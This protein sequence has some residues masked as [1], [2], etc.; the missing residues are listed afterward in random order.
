M[1]TCILAPVIWYDYKG[2]EICWN[3]EQYVSLGCEGG[4]N[5]LE[6]LDEFWEDYFKAMRL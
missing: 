2:D 6:L 3:G 1:I 4:F 5:S